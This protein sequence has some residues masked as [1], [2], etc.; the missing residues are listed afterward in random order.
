MQRH[1][2]PDRA[3]DTTDRNFKTAEASAAPALT[4]CI[5]V[6]QKLCLNITAGAKCRIQLSIVSTSLTSL[7]VQCL[8]FSLLQSLEAFTSQ[9]LFCPSS[10]LFLSLP[11]STGLALLPISSSC[12][13]LQL[14]SGAAGAV[15]KQDGHH[16]PHVE[17]LGACGQQ[18]GIW[19]SAVPV[20]AP[21]YQHRWHR[22]C[23]VLPRDQKAC[24]REEQIVKVQVNTFEP[25]LVLPVLTFSLLQ[26]PL[27]EFSCC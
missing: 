22:N 12:G 26:L 5:L 25:G 27:Q 16:N 4:A 9:L 14:L 7:S 17:S 15:E 24:A 11:C 3:V 21:N 13:C 19:S 6:F 8:F 23:K 20:T 18:P 10:S 2:P 1:L